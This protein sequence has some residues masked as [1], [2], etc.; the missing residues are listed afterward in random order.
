MFTK[1]C[2]VCR[3]PASWHWVWRCWDFDV[4]NPKN[5]THHFPIWR[6]ITGRRQNTRAKCASR[7]LKFCP[8]DCL[9]FFLKSH[10]NTQFSLRF[11]L[12]L[13][14]W[15]KTLFMVWYRLSKF[16]VTL[17]VDGRFFLF[18]S[19]RRYSGIT[20]LVVCRFG[21]HYKIVWNLN[22]ISLCAQVN[23]FIK[24]CKHQNCIY[25]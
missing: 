8:P 22:G 14:K 6:I 10:K 19:L 9:N 7:K 12:L 23:V 21:F 11:I 20:E 18:F 3:I 16:K 1:L 5:L 4:G 13:K 25:K 17:N 24:M 15:T 2:T